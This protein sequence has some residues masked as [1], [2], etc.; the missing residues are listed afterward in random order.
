MDKIS[1]NVERVNGYWTVN[2][3]P[4]TELDYAEKLMLEEFLRYAREQYKESNL[5]NK[6]NE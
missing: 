3:K 6:E 5:E 4:Y 2:G 1:F